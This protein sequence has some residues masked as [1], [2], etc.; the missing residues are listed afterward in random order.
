MTDFTKTTNVGDV[1]IEIGL[2]FGSAWGSITFPEEWTLE[3]CLNKIDDKLNY[4]LRRELGNINGLSIEITSH[5]I[6]GLTEEEAKMF[7]KMS[8][9]ICYGELVRWYLSHNPSE[10]GC[11]I[12]GCLV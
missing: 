5:S 7:D 2:D 11:V 3:E 8:V 10:R 12:G 4:T 1:D 9:D 6:D